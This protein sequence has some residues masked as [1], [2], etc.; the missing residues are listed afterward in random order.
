[1][2]VIAQQKIEAGH[3]SGF[4]QAKLD[5]ARF[6]MTRMLPDHLALAAKIRAGASPI[7][8]TQDEYL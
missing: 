5:T 2:A 7:M 4:Y 6:F 3:A 1:M 8:N